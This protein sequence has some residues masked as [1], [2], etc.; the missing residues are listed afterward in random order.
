M[1]KIKVNHKTAVIT[2]DINME[3]LRRVLAIQPNAAKLTDE[4]GQTVFAIGMGTQ[5]FI[6]QNG[7]VFEKGDNKISVSFDAKPT[8]ASIEESL[9]MCLYNL[10]LMEKA[11]KKVI[12]KID[13]DMEGLVEIVD[14]EGAAE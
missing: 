10:A 4:N 7:V 14:E 3:D 9:G 13:K 11:I 5:A 1:A 12:K 8:K 6:N 2:A